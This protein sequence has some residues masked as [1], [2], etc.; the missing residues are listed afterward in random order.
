[1]VVIDL[2]DSI[3]KG[4]VNYDMVKKGQTEQVSDRYSDDVVTCKMTDTAVVKKLCSFTSDR[5]TKC[6]IVY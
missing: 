4:S 3:K 5:Q 2:V 1:M 6:L